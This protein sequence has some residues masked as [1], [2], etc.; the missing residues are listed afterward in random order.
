MDSVNFFIRNFIGI[1]KS[2]VMGTL[3]FVLCCM[4]LH[5]TWLIKLLKLFKKNIIDSIKKPFYAFVERIT[6]LFVYKNNLSFNNNEQGFNERVKYLLTEN[7]KIEK[8][9]YAVDLCCDLF[10]ML[11]FMAGNQDYNVMVEDAITYLEAYMHA[12]VDIDQDGEF[13]Y[14]VDKEL[15]TIT[16]KI[17]YGGLTDGDIRKLTYNVSAEL[18]D[19]K[20]Q[21]NNL[22]DKNKKEI[23]ELIKVETNAK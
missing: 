19:L 20:K 2:L 4:M 23:V 5:D 3:C 6:G 9:V 10:E 18:K 1:I 11:S 21:L 22:L 16:T 12:F 13:K 15:E 7:E 14:K 8:N 17:Q